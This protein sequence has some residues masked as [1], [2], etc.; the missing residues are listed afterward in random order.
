[1]SGTKGQHERL[2][3]QPAV[4]GPPAR[5]PRP[6]REMERLN[7]RRKNVSD[8]ARSEAAELRDVQDVGIFAHDTLLQ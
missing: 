7:R 3:Q 1:M 5:L 4:Q 8:G 6:K 2:V